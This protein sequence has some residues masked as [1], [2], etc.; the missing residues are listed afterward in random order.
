MGGIFSWPCRWASVWSKSSVRARILQVHPLDLPLSTLVMSE[1][2]S[3]NVRILQPWQWILYVTIFSTVLTSSSD[4]PFLFFRTSL[5]PF[6]LTFRMLCLDC[7][8]AAFAIFVKFS[9]YSC[10]TLT[11]QVSKTWMDGWMTWIL[12]S[13][14]VCKEKDA[15]NI[16]L[17]NCINS[18][19]VHLCNYCTKIFVIVVNTCVCRRSVDNKA[20]ILSYPILLFTPLPPPPLTTQKKKQEITC[21]ELP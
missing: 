13:K 5:M 17:S 2:S 19:N 7:S 1:G 3:G 20:A 16:N 15:L 8:H 10:V 12:V 14:Y 4:L 18:T 6:C 9:R 11:I 21:Y